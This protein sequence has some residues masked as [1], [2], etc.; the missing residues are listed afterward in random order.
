MPAPPH[1]GEY[2][3]PSDAQADDAPATFMTAE[4]FADLPD[5]GT[6]YE[7]IAGVPVAMS[8]PKYHHGRTA[9]KFTAI[10]G[11]YILSEGLGEALTESGFLLARNPDTVRGPD[12]A[13]I[14]A[15]RTLPEHKFDTY[16]EGAPDLAVE[17]ISTHDNAID[18]RTK[19]LQYLDAGARLVWVLYPSLTLID[20]SRADGSTTVLRG[21]AALDGEEV[22]PGLTIPVQTIFE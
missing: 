18:L 4:A 15:A 12:F 20:V 22:L 6:R 9:G 7:L 16:F 19:V 1:R 3:A 5:T 2:T 17:I 14:S 11:H 10:V 8:R 13:F 21:D